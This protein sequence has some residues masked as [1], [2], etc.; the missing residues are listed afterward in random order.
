MQVL[1]LFIA[2]FML[3]SKL[4]VVIGTSAG[5]TNPRYFSLLPGKVHRNSEVFLWYPNYVAGLKMTSNV[6]KEIARTNTLSG[7][8]STKCH[9]QT[10]VLYAATMH[11]S[12]LWIYS[13][14]ISCS[15]QA[16]ELKIAVFPIRW[17]EMDL[18]TSPSTFIAETVW[19]R[20][21]AP[22]WVGAYFKEPGPSGQSAKKD[23]SFH[24]TDTFR[25]RKRHAKGET[26]LS[27]AWGFGLH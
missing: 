23:T 24:Q 26:G 19:A 14:H 9:S 12:S 1:Y 10:V 13:A 11:P 7:F 22:V 27:H 20:G 21:R 6:L 15:L 3:V 8:Y 5:T 18:E 25:S 16:L 4:K 2:I 17:L